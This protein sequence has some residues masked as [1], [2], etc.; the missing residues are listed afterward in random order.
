MRSTLLT[1]IAIVLVGIMVI[2][3]CSGVTPSIKVGVGHQFPGDSDS[4]SKELIGWAWSV[5]GS[6]KA[7]FP[8]AGPVIEPCG[9]VGYTRSVLNL[10]RDRST[11]GVPAE[12]CVEIDTTMVTR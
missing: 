4:T 9:A 1:G 5:G 11:T 10:D 2:G 3:G 7:S 12:F 6:I 8:Q